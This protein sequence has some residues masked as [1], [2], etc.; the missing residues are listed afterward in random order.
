M[1]RIAVSKM[2]GAVR[3]VSFTAVL[4][5]AILRCSG[6]ARP[7][8]CMFSTSCGRTSSAGDRAAVPGPSLRARAVAGRSASR[9]RHC[10]GQSLDTLDIAEFKSRATE[11]AATRRRFVEDGFA[12]DRHEHTFTVDMRY[13]G[14]SFTL[15]IPC[16]PDQ[17][18]YQMTARSIS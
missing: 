10:L 1:L 9:F 11:C 4:I 14:Q 15:S 18:S 8:R 17:A 16:D 7:G 2:A 3:E 5:R 12:E 13:V 6:S